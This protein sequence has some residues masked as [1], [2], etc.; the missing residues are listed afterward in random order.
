[1]AI[2]RGRPKDLELGEELRRLRPEP[3]RELVDAIV[4]RLPSLETPLRR[5]RAPRRLALAAALTVGLAA[6]TGAMGGVGKGASA[7]AAAVQAVAKVVSPP[8]SEPPPSAPAAAPAAPP[9]SVTTSSAGGNKVTICHLTGS[10]SN[11]WVVITVSTS[12]IPAHNDHGDIIPAPASGCPSDDDGPGGDQYKP[13][14]GCGDK[15][16]VHRRE[17][18]CKKAP[19]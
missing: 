1:M 3:R 17:N 2:F 11:P 15:N 13:G 14:K 4:A 9:A 18:E 12:A 6:A 16:H 8:P 5:T 7:T 19:K 10:T